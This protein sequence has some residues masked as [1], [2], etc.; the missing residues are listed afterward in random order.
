MKYH[1]ESI[2]FFKLYL[3]K[4]ISFKLKLEIKR[5]FF[6]LCSKFKNLKDIIFVLKLKY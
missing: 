1:M 3:Y 5:G 2:F 6:F 4:A